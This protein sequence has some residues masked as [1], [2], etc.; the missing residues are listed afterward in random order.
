MKNL[1]RDG[2]LPLNS[3]YLPPLKV[4]NLHLQHQQQGIHL[5]PRLA[6]P[7]V[8]QFK[9]TTKVTQN[10]PQQVIMSPRANISIFKSPRN[11]QAKQY[12]PQLA[13]LDEN[14]ETIDTLPSELYETI[15]KDHSD[16]TPGITEFN[17]LNLFSPHVCEED[18]QEHEQCRDRLSSRRRARRERREKRINS[19][20]SQNESENDN[21][22]D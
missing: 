11:T 14:Y 4:P 9:N 2:G 8:L 12:S 17:N 6:R 16:D 10:R 5:S 1:H 7:P 18:E 20:D 15:G 19:D 22:S 13:P 21:E 3:P